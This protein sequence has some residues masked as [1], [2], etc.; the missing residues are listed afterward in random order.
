MDYLN[1]PGV[2][3]YTDVN[4]NNG[5]GHSSAGQGDDDRSCSAGWGGS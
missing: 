3:V 5:R 2:E 4:R 1:M